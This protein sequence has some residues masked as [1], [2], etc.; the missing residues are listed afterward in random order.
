MSAS[1]TLLLLMLI[2]LR[3]GLQPSPGCSAFRKAERGCS[4]KAGRWRLRPSNSDWPQG[5]IG[6]AEVVAGDD[7]AS[8]LPFCW[9]T[10]PILRGG[11]AYMIKPRLT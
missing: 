1:L 4:V 7:G 2:D 11:I 6:F 8:I 3:S 5:G 10:K 9:R